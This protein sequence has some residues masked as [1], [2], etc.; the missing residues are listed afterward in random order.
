VSNIASGVVTEVVGDSITV[1]VGGLPLNVA[2]S[3][4]T[5]A[6]QAGAPVDVAIRAERVNL[7]RREPGSAGANVLEAEI[8]EEFAYG[9]T[10]TLHLAPAGIG[11]ALEVEIAARPYEVLDVAHRRH[12][13]VELPAED[14]HLM[15]PG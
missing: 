12:W 14:L 4:A 9:S 5:P 13:L 7:R 15:L 3:Q 2:R 6:L 1:E 8:V 10:H 11:P